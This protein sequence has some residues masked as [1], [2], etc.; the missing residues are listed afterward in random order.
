MGNLEQWI[1]LVRDLGFPGVLLI[2]VCVAVWKSGRW[3]GYQVI[4]PLR[5]RFIIFLGVLEKTQKHQAEALV[6][7]GQAFS[8]HDEWERRTIAERDFKMDKIQTQ[9]NVLEGRIISM[10]SK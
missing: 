4:I 8:S 3:V 9:V 6:S 1:A 2:F 5:N 10:E 7:L